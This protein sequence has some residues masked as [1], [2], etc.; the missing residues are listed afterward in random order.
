MKNE[1]KKFIDTNLGQLLFV[2]I[3][4]GVVY[5]G[6]ITVKTTKSMSPIKEHY[7]FILAILTIFTFYGI[8]EIRKWIKKKY[9]QK[10]NQS[11]VDELV[12]HIN[13]QIKSMN[14][15]IELIDMITK[16]IGYSDNFDDM[17]R[18]LKGSKYTVKKLIKYEPGN[19]KE[20]DI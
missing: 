2:V 12:K 15:N 13:M 11:E 9:Q 18:E 14:H 16:E 7:P 5:I 17:K 6:L 1:I 3:P 8:N 20:K 19:T 10:T 4:G